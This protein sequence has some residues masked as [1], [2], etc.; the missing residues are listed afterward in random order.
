MILISKRLWPIFLNM[1][2]DNYFNFCFQQYGATCHSSLET[3]DCC[4]KKFPGCVISQLG[5]RNWQARSCD[6]TLWDFFFCLWE[7]SS[8]NSWV[9]SWQN[10]SKLYAVKAEQHSSPAIYAFSRN[11]TTNG[12]FKVLVRVVHCLTLFSWLVSC[13]KLSAKMQANVFTNMSTLS[14]DRLSTVH[15]KHTF[16]KE[17][18]STW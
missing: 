15:M 1:D 16:H 5:D 18:S 9:L 6:L 10:R 3:V 14:S 13:L 2:I 4:L 17:L 12:A 7:L 11:P 8:N